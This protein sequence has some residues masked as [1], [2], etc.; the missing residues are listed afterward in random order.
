MEKTHRR[1]EVGK[2]EKNEQALGAKKYSYRYRIE[3]L[4]VER[5]FHARRIPRRVVFHLPS[6]VLRDQRRVLSIGKQDHR[7]SIPS[8]LVIG[9]VGSAKVFWPTRS[10]YFRDQ[11]IS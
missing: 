3:G 9:R 10:R 7:I 6:R 11:D 4:L 2:G 5:G 1:Q 8:G